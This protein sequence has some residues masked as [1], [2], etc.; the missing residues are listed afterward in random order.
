MERAD[1]RNH[2]SSIS[3]AHSFLFSFF[4][5]CLQACVNFITEHKIHPIVAQVFKGLESTDAA[6]SVMAAGQ[7]FG[8]LVIE[9]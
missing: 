4:G 6:F 3:V 5:F 2:R 8:K 1:T 9:F 7:Q